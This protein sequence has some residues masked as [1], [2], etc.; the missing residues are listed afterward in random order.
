MNICIMYIY[1]V[2]IHAF[3]YIHTI[4]HVYTYI[5]ALYIC[6]YLHICILPCFTFSCAIGLRSD[7]EDSLQFVAACCIVLCRICIPLFV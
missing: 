3:V 1:I 6:L 7:S 5:Q 2:H 4:L